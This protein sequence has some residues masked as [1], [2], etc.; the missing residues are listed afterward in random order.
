LHVD[1]TAVTGTWFRHVPAGVDAHYRPPDA[2]D[3]RWKIELPEVADLGDD[4][5]LARVGLPPPIP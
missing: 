1:S 4:D 2:A 3:N 5:R